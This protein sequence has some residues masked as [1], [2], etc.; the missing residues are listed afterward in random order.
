MVI[1]YFVYVGLVVF[2]Y[3]YLTRKNQKQLKPVHQ[4][5]NEDVPAAVENDIPQI[6]IPDGTLRGFSENSVAPT[7]Y[8]QR[9]ILFEN[10]CVRN[11]LQALK[12]SLLLITEWNEISL[13]SKIFVLITAPID[14][15]CNLTILP[16]GVGEIENPNQEIVLALRFINRIRAILYPWFAFPLIV[17]VFKIQSHWINEQFPVFG[18]YPLIAIP[19]SLILC[20]Q[21]SW[22][23]EPK[24]MYSHVIISFAMCILWIYASSQELVELLSSL[25]VIMGVSKTILGITV[26]AWGNSFGDF[27]ANT[28]MSRAGLTETAITAVFSAPVQNVLLNIGV[29]FLTAALSSDGSSFHLEKLNATIFIGLGFIGTFIFVSVPLIAFYWKFN[30]PKYFG[31]ML[32]GFYMT[33]IPIAIL[34]ELNIINFN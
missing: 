23:S 30:V 10:I 18:L 31:F 33:Y 8:C 3:F 17:I 19:L 24:F 9:N 12:K 14:L 20:K 13:V 6:V 1:T 27:V 22:K 26:L 16:L 4:V 29:S 15:L 28:M 5:S 32:I 11:F 25:G 2:F 34:T 7:D 21:T